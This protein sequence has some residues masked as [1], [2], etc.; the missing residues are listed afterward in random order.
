M[1]TPHSQRFAQLFEKLS[2]RGEGAFVPFI[3]LGDPSPQESLEILHV[4]AEAGADAFELGIPFSDPSA[5]GPVIAVSAQRALDVGATPEACLAVI[6]KFRETHPDVPVSIMLYMNLVYAPGVN[7]F[8]AACR[9]AGVDAVL[10]P[11]LPVSMREAVPEY[12]RAAQENGIDLISIVPPNVDE[13]AVRHIA[14]F[15]H[16]YTYLMSRVGITGIDRA[17]GIP[18]ER[19]VNLLKE[20]DAA[21]GLVGFGISTP[22]QVRAVLQTGAAGVVVGSAVVNII[23]QHPDDADE[24]NRALTEYV[25]AMKAATRN[26]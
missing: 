9:K 10:I 6:E 3:T 11:D 26:T 4:L 12:D 19:C 24:R 23:S 8:F 1:T 13:A 22:E 21:P 17:A 18:T 15:A 2:A 7:N 5:D 14:P 25:R 16:G 20:L